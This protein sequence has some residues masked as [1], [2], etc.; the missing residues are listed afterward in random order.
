MTRRP[1]APRL[2]T[3]A[4][5]LDIRKA[6]DSVSS[7]RLVLN[8]KAHAFPPP[9]LRSTVA[10]YALARVVMHKGKRGSQQ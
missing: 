10:S 3:A 8:A 2:A 7:G 1:D 9:V 6:S 5:L 4:V